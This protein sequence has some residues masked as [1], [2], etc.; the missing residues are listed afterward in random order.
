MTAPTFPCFI[1]KTQI[2][3]ELSNFSVYQGWDDIRDQSVVY[4]DL[5]K[6][7]CFVNNTTDISVHIGIFCNSVKV[8]CFVNLLIRNVRVPVKM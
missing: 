6:V 1:K 4:Q 2:N 5:S 3:P 8:P 7:P